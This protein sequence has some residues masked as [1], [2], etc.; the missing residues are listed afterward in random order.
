MLVKH[1]LSHVIENM[2]IRVIKEKTVLVTV[3]IHAKY[4]K[5]CLKRE[6]F[7]RIH[8]NVRSA[9]IEKKI[10]KTMLLSEDMYRSN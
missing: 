7:T 1:Y 3:V 2:S 6:F 9:C 10:T 8:K 4:P 5:L